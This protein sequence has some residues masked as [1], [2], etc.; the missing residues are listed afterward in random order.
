M[1]QLADEKTV[2][3]PQ[4]VSTFR[5][6]HPWT[7]EGGKLAREFRFSDFSSA[8]GFMARA[9]LIFESADHHPL[10]TN[11]YSRVRVR[12]WTQLAKGLTARDLQVAEQLDALFEATPAA[13]AA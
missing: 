2:L 9:A 1:K 8:F 5:A 13:V 6:A 10:W 12:L 7:L 3:H 4:A 11:V